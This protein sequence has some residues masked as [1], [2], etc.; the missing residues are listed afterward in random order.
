MFNR[1][2]LFT[3]I[4]AGAGAMGLARATSAS[5]ATRQA[6]TREVYLLT[7]QSNMVGFQYGAA[8]NAPTVTPAALTI[9]AGMPLAVT[10][11]NGP[12]NPLD[13]VG[14]YDET[15]AAWI[16]WLYLNGHQ[17]ELRPT[18]GCTH[19]TVIFQ[20][21]T[22]GHCYTFRLMANNGYQQLACSPVVTVTANTTIL[23]PPPE[24]ITYDHAARIARYAQAWNGSSTPP[25]PTSPSDPGAG[26]WLPA[27]DPLHSHPLAGVG[28]GMAFADRLLTLRDDAQLEIGL[29]PCAHGGS[30][31]HP[32]WEPTYDTLRLFT[33]AVA[34]GRRAQTWGPIKGILHYGGET[35]AMG[36]DPTAWSGAV[37]RLMDGLRRELGDPNI[38]VIVTR[39]GPNPGGF[40]SWAGIQAAADAMVNADPRLAVVSASDL[41]VSP[42]DPLHL[43]AASAVTLGQRYAD[44]IVGL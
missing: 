3:R 18:A 39:L 34:R 44:A 31:E 25:R 36:T 13:W 33:T 42:T 23:T 9:A 41:Q 15:G 2:T 27:T 6:P 43:T 14:L 38:P 19:A 32:D 29:V 1:R 21:L 12:A 26:V 22:I 35:M 37:W 11:A 4:V 20:A 24:S 5:V 8:L 17:A 16:T 7:G 10:V 40:P 28:P 30:S